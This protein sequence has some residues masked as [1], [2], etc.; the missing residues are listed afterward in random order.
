MSLRDSLQ[1][2]LVGRYKV[3]GEI[4]RGAT[5]TVY[6]AED[7]KHDRK[8]AI[9]VFRPEFA[10]SVGTERFLREIQV[11][12]QLQHPHTLMLI[13]SG[14]AADKLFYVMPYN[15]GVAEGGPTLPNAPWRPEVR[16]VV[17]E[18][19]VAVMPPRYPT[20]CY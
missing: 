9:K 14:M 2:E 20:P 15:A 19:R 17:G 12:A 3:D 4:G 13:D 16:S 10:V 1:A 6:L 11:A 8:V 5:A 18:G 7:L